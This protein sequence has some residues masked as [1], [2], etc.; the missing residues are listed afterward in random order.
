M[1]C[2]VEL[3]RKPGK[4]YV[5]AK[6]RGGCMEKHARFSPNEK[7]SNLLSRAT[8]PRLD[9]SFYPLEMQKILIFSRRFFHLLLSFSSW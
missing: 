4:R 8:F 1:P 7:L 5:S 9:R 3:G 6:R 2:T